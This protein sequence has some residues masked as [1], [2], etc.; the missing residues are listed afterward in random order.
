M[1]VYFQDGYLTDSHST[2]WGHWQSDVKW[3]QHY[4]SLSRQFWVSS[5]NPHPSSVE[6]TP[7]SSLLEK[8]PE[9][10]SSPTWQKTTLAH[11]ELSLS[12]DDGPY[13][14]ESYSTLNPLCFQ[15]NYSLF[16]SDQEHVKEHERGGS[17]VSYGRSELCRCSKQ[18]QR[19][20]PARK[21]WVLQFI[22]NIIFAWISF[23][24][25]GN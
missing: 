20:R 16:I 21:C 11:W 23:L 6:K 9:E 25:K 15:W 24:G 17:E 2:L 19:F 14:E 1:C 22:K 7:T 3:S 8:G 12:Q 5:I 4:L 10:G 18:T 13:S